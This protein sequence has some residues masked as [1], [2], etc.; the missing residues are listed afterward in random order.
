MGFNIL[1]GFDE[2]YINSKSVAPGGSA[3]GTSDMDNMPLNKIVW[4]NTASGS[5]AHAP[6]SGAYHVLTVKPIA[7]HG[8][9]IALHYAGTVMYIRTFT[10]SA[11]G[12][13]RSIALS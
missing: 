4:I 10:D 8:F 7:T 12:N 6:S 1:C 13:W 3:N 5:V 2:H 9:Q 11:W